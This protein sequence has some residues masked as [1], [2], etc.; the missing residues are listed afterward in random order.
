MHYSANNTQLNVLES[1]NSPLTL[2][3]LHYFGGS[4]IE[5]KFIMAQLASQYRCVAV[6][7]RGHGDSSAP[8]TGYSIADMADDVQAL[9]RVMGIQDFVL[10]GHSMS[11]KVALELASRQPAGLQLVL[12]VSPSP[13]VPEPISDT[14]RQEMLETHG[15]Q[16][17]AEETCKKITAKFLPESAKAQIT[18]DN[19]RTSKTAWNAWLTLGS[20]ENISE[21]MGLVSVPVHIIAGTKDKAIPPDVQPEMTLPYLPGATLDRIE[22]AGHLLPWETPDELTAFIRGKVGAIVL[23]RPA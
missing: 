2:V 22:G 10:V 17:A 16:T 5:W 8:E 12:L 23:E 18:T 14:D 19:L 9:I 7:L 3:F 20:K 11:G 15:Q 21:R 13:P 1:G 6:D 4:A